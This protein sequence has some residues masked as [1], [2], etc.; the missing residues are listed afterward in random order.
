MTVSLPLQPQPLSAAIADRLRQRILQG[1]WLPGQD[2][3]DGSVAHSLGVSRTPVREAMKVLCHEGLLTTHPRRGMTVA[4]LTTDQVQEAHR[5]R[6]VLCT[7]QA[8]HPQ[9]DNGLTQ[10]MMSMTEQRIALSQLP[11]YQAD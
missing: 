5:L 11:I 3:N 9:V 6:E 4:V 1:E 2:V 8:Q 10:R 7:L